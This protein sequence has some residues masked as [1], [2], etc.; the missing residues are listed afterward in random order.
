M[1][2]GEM[3]DDIRSTFIFGS[4]GLAVVASMNERNKAKDA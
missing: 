3:K 1:E 2:E 4:I